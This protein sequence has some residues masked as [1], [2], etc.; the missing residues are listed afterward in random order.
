VVG[1]KPFAGANTE[2]A[3]V[4][5]PGEFGWF[6]VGAAMPPPPVGTRGVGLGTG[7]DGLESLEDGAGA[8]TSGSPSAPGL[9]GAAD[10]EV[11]GAPVVGALV[12]GDGLEGVVGGEVDGAAVVGGAVEGTGLEPDE[13]NS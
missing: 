5:L 2:G 9:L 3:V 7:D 11:A 12:V 8:A 1:A 10:S 13:R 6:E 4:G